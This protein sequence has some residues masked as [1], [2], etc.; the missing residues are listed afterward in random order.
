MN[1]QGWR[2][3]ID[4][5]LGEAQFLFYMQKFH[6]F[7]ALPGRLPPDFRMGLSGKLCSNMDLNLAL[8]V[9]FLEI[10]KCT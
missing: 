10:F 7:A 2:Y 1:R 5:T 3:F 8:P 6:S 4:G 9:N